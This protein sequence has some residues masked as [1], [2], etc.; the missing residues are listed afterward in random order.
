M[1]FRQANTWRERGLQI[2][3]IKDKCNSIIENLNL[4]ESD[5]RIQ[6]MIHV[7]GLCNTLAAIPIKLQQNAENPN[8]ISAILSLLGLSSIDDLSIILEDFNANSKIGFITSVQ[9]ALENCIVRIIEAIPGV[10]PQFSFSQNADIIIE[11][12]EIPQA[13]HKLDLMLLPA[14]I[15]NTL[16]ANG[17][18]NRSNRTIV[19]DGESYIFERGQ[20]IAGGTWSHLFHAISHSLVVVEEIFI[21][22]RIRAIERIQSI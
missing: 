6:G 3:E 20:R 2:Q 15:R 11:Q 1:P 12:S 19:V 21:S 10:D 5:V 13:A 4:N 18:H 17:I 22:D 9:F 8:N 14:W 16:H 7:R